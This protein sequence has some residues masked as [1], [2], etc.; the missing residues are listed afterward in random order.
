MKNPSILLAV[1]NHSL[2]DFKTDILDEGTLEE[3][4]PN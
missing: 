4:C 1:Y 3:N 2:V